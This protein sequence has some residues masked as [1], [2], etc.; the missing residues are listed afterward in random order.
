M[1]IVSAVSGKTLSSHHENGGTPLVFAVF[2]LPSHPFRLSQRRP[3]FE[4]N[5]VVGGTY[6]RKSHAPV[7]SRAGLNF[8]TTFK[9]AT[10]KRNS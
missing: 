1:F 8:A 6:E 5:G 4:R 7:N 9:G 10:S 3:E 2:V